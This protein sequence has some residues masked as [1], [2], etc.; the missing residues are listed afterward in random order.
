M[1]SIFAKIRQETT[2]FNLGD[3][4]VSRWEQRDFSRNWN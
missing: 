4:E 3:E 2:N 1:E